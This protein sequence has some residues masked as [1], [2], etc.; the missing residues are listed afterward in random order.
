MLKRYDKKLSETSNKI[1]ELD[2]KINKMIKKEIKI[3]YY[4]NIIKII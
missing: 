2:K 3:F 1:N 4:N